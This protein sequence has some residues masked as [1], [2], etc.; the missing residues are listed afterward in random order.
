MRYLQNRHVNDTVVLTMHAAL[1]VMSGLLHL[2]Y[3]YGEKNAF[4]KKLSLYSA[5]A[6]CF[7]T[8]LKVEPHVA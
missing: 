8:Y 7:L 6:R 4:S 1:K 2:L 3:F 5:L